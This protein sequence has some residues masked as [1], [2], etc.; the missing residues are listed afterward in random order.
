MASNFFLLF[1]Q[2]KLSSL[3]E[4]KKKE[5]IEKIELTVIEAVELFEYGKL[6]ESY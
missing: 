5:M 1:D 4:K 2:L 3:S 6:N